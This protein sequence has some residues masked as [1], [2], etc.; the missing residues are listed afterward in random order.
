MPERANS[1]V[2][3]IPANATHRVLSVPRLHSRIARCHLRRRLKPTLPDTAFKWHRHSCL[4]A[5]V[6]LQPFR[7][8]LAHDIAL[9]ELKRTGV[10]FRCRLTGES[11]PLKPARMAPRRQVLSPGTACRA[12]TDTSRHQK[13]C[14]SKLF[15]LCPSPPLAP[16]SRCSIPP[17]FRPA[18]RPIAPTWNFFPAACARARASSRNSRCSRAR[19]T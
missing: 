9:R 16:G 8:W 2:R 1:A 19:P 4:C 15:R 10:I 18:C 5:F 13:P 17:T 14:P 11:L 12:P 6:T 7:T 3:A